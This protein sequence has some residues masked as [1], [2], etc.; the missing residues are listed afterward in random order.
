M[1]FKK[2]IIVVVILL[3]AEVLASVLVWSGKPMD[4]TWEPSF[5]RFEASRLRYWVLFVS[6][7]L[8]TAQ[9][10]WYGLARL[11]WANRD[12]AATVSRIAVAFCGALALA[13]EYLTS[14]YYS[15]SLSWSVASYV[16]WPH[17]PRYISDHLWSWLFSSSVALRGVVCPGDGGGRGWVTKNDA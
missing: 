10:A 13:A 6:I 9:F 7:F 11:K 3:V 8:A 2:T 5:W 4:G 1:P 12:R 16:G 15:R 14:L 17:R